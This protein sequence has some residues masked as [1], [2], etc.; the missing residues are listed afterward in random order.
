MLDP[1]LLRFVEAPDL[2]CAEQELQDIVERH[3][4]PLAEAIVARKLRSFAVKALPLR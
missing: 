3:A 1:L 2:A 4:L